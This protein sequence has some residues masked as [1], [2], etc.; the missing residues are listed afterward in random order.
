MIS[1][2]VAVDYVQLLDFEL[3][4][5]FEDLEMSN[6]DDLVNFEE[7]LLKDKGYNSLTLSIFGEEYRLLLLQLLVLFVLVLLIIGLSCI[8][9]RLLSCVITIDL[10]EH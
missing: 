3:L 10:S 8:L 5:I 6:G 9:V 2:T 7:D 4:N 1:S